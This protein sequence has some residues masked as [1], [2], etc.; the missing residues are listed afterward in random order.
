[1]AKKKKAVTIALFLIATITSTSFILSIANAAEAPTFPF[2]SVV[3]NPVGVG[4]DVQVTMWLSSPPPGL[5]GNPLAQPDMWEG[6]EIEVTDP[7]EHT[8]TLG[9]FTSDPTGSAFTK[10][11]PDQVGTYYFQFNCPPQ[12]IFDGTPYERDYAASSTPKLAVTVQQEPIP[13]YPEWPL[14]TDYWQRPINAE[15][16]LWANISGNWLG[17]EW[18]F[19]TTRDGQSPFNPYST[20]P[21]TAHIVW[22]KPTGIGGLVGGEYGTWSFSN[23]F[24]FRKFHPPVIMAGRLYYN[25]H[26]NPRTGF[27]CVDLRTGETIWYRNFTSPSANVAVPGPDFG[28][29]TYNYITNGQL[30]TY[31]NFNQQGAFAYLWS[32]MGNGSTVWSMYDAWSGNWILD[33]VNVPTA[34]PLPTGWGPPIRFG[35]NGEMLVYVLNPFANI[36]TL[37]NSTK[38][39]PDPGR[40]TPPTGATLDGSAGIE[41]VVPITPVPSGTP[42]QTGWL[43]VIQ[44]VDDVV[45][46]AT[47]DFFDPWDNITYVAYSA[48][49]GHELWSDTRIL[50]EPKTTYSLFGPAG[51]GVFTEFNKETMTWLGYDIQTGAKL[52]GPVTVG[53]NSWGMYGGYGVIAYGKL[54]TAGY[55]G[56]IHC[57]DVKTGEILWEFYDGNSGTET[58]YGQDPFYSLAALTVADGKVFAATGEHS[59]S[60]PTTRGGGIFAVDAENGTLLW[61]INGRYQ[62]RTAIA[63][64]YLVTY[65]WDDQQI[66][67]FGKGKTATTVSASPKISVHGNS[68]IIEGTVLDQSPGAEGTAA[69]A[70]EYMTPWMQYLYMQRPVPTNATGVEVTL[71]VLDANNNYRNIG[72]TTS[73]ANGAFSFVWEPDIPGKYTVYATFAGSG[74]YWS[75]WA[76]T[77]FNVEEAAATAEPTPQPAS[78]ADLYFLPMSIGIIVAIVVVGLLLF[79][80]L[81][82]R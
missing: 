31:T 71:D 60:Q 26:N 74:S 41:W 10:Y 48:K 22:N 32:T 81:R 3:P 9:P 43:K 80:L 53:N 78:V 44:I 70:D 77:A 16:R 52:W 12:T 75:S 5:P 19:L 54:F 4:Q 51:E 38:A 55:D 40:W 68:I 33:I 66:Y 37:W 72:T 76:E 67:C 2:M 57:L 28:E 79:L 61:K 36:L 11:T 49:D 64:G 45:L 27:Y 7:N 17:I 34:P 65:N 62:S 35:Q 46:A 56:A 39:I 20:A 23:E 59:P 25:E 73:D 47:G 29:H 42:G 58:P 6:Y 30:L 69:I 1:M 13:N 14:P 18:S 24:Y 82:K 50:A 63:D 15:N 21:S 8:E